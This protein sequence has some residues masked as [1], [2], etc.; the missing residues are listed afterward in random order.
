M[1]NRVEV[2]RGDNEYGYGFACCFQS[3]APEEG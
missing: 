1:Q 2:V 3:L